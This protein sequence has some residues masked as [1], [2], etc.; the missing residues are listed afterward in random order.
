MSE[1]IT[2]I[3]EYLCTFVWAHWCRTGQW[4]TSEGQ[5]VHRRSSFTLYE[6]SVRRS[7]RLEKASTLEICRFCDNRV[8]EFFQSDHNIKLNFLLGV[9]LQKCP[10][11]CCQLCRSI[12]VR[13]L[14]DFWDFIC[15]ISLSI[16]FFLLTNHSKVKSF[17][18]LEPTLQDGR[19]CP[20]P[21][22]ACLFLWRTIIHL[23][24]RYF[25]LVN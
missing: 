14:K 16:F 5:G 11:V 24:L 3:L 2:C 21:G 18:F 12:H 9:C 13:H 23:W 17:Y 19:S 10:A 4:K 22:A 20:N 15:P 7:R 1:P 25:I 8:S 6:S